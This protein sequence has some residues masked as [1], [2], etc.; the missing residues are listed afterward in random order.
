MLKELI[1]SLIIDNDFFAKLKNSS[2]SLDENEIFFHSL[3]KT[4]GTLT[5][6]ALT[7]AVSVEWDKLGIP[8]IT[9]ESREDVSY[10]LGY[11]HAQERYFQMDLLRRLAAGELSEL[12]GGA[13]ELIETDIQNRRWLLRSR[14][15]NTLK[16]LSVDEK[17]ILAQYTKG[18][19]E[20]LSSKIIVSF[21]YVILMTEATPWKD[22]DSLLVLYALSLELQQQQ[23]ARV[24]A[25]G[26]IDQHSTAAQKSFLLPE[27]SS[28]DTPLSGTTPPPPSI[29]ETP[30]D[31]W[32]KGHESASTLP[33]QAPFYGSNCFVIDGQHSKN[34]QAILANDMHLSLMLPNTWYRA[35]LNYLSP[36]KKHTFSLSG[37][38]LP[39]VPVV[40]IGCN[41]HIS[42]GFTH[43][44][45]DTLDWVKTPEP[46]SHWPVETEYI[47]VKHSEDIKL[48]I[49][50]SPYGPV[51]ATEQGNMAMRWAMQLPDAIDLHFLA[52]N[53]ALCV[54][55][56]ID[57]GTG[58]GMPAL[59]M[60]VADKN[61][62]IG[63]AL[64][65]TLPD[66]I[67]KGDINT[68][69][70]DEKNQ[71][72][73]N[74]LAAAQHPHILNPSSGILWNANNRQSFSSDYDNIGDGGADI[75]VRAWEIKQRLIKDA[76]L[77]ADDMRA[78][79][80]DNTANLFITWRLTLLPLIT[81]SFLIN[82]PLRRQ[83]LDLIYQW[84]GS[85]GTDSVGYR[86][87]SLWRDMI[88][89]NLFGKLDNQLAAQWPAANYL[90][91]NTR[92]DET[93]MALIN[94]PQQAAWVP[95]GFTGWDDFI[96][97]Q[98]DMV[99]AALTAQEGQLF[100]AT[101]G[102][103]NTAAIMHPFA[104]DMPAL[105]PL[106]SAPADELSGDH[107]V[108]HV[109]RPDFGASCRLVAYPG[110]AAKGTLT[111]PGG[112]S[113]HPISPWFLAGHEY[114]VHGLSLPLEPGPVQKTL[115]MQ[116]QKSETVS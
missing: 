81:D 92:W 87:I 36:D 29:A 70:V 51:V 44:Y 16:N 18:V 59:N 47:K 35:S 25:R 97:S 40:I 75:G 69:P 114:W 58:S 39:G 98:L 82:Q 64:V 31:W 112:Q 41:Q 108:P 1:E 48:D 37:L 85:A 99:L 105:R 90:T 106:L 14:A 100:H 34:G 116:P 33:S 3:P 68:F 102:K 79:Q 54:S 63:W 77:N 101:W 15:I 91:A 56:A 46:L 80:L 93:V 96:V 109:C 86:I 76:K 24:Y 32:G 78:I 23:I 49:P 84:G 60:F 95:H 12:L 5:S 88:Y 28:W 83:A 30:P 66:R 113:G 9:G 62:D 4:E 2:C 20:G 50:L 73:D 65:G 8:T 21:E 107:N 53:E 43:S 111:Q 110:D 94:T 61:G 42:W 72:Q 7:N 27:S 13:K 45:A 67:I 38:T 74:V 55:Q 115:M 26:W 10:S 22:E 11:I 57:I 104:K 6:S 71:W 52:I 19:N 17:N 89:K 103:A